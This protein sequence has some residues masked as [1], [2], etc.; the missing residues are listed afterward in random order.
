MRFLVA[1]DKFKD[2]LSAGYVCRLASEHL[3]SGLPNVRVSEIPLTDG[4]EGF[5]DI[6]TGAVGGRFSSHIV[7][8]PLGQPVDVRIGYVELGLLS[9]KVRELANLPSEGEVAV[10]EM[11][12]AAGLEQVP[13]PLRDPWSAS[14]FGVGELVLHAVEDGAAAILLGIGGSATNDLGF[15][16]LRA[17]GLRFFDDED[18]E[19][20]NVCPGAWSGIARISGELPELPPL[21]IACDV[22]NPLLGSTGASA[23]YGPQKGLLAEDILQMDSEMARMAS[24][25]SDQFGAKKDM[26]TAPGT[27]AAG[28]FGFGLSVACGGCFVE[29]FPLVSAW[30]ELEEQINDAE[31]I[32]TGEGRFDSTSLRG[33][34]PGKVL[35]LAHLAGKPVFVLA[36]SVSEESRREVR[37]VF[38][39]AFL[40]SI[41]RPELSLEENLSRTEEFFEQTL[42]KIV[43]DKE[44]TM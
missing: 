20:E 3:E 24:M 2:A 16:A 15:G 12:S 39:R 28:G 32:L 19:I 35:E 22:D 29:G 6:L 44:W 7:E 27:G 36:G 30:L 37:E 4:G 42:Q 10:L 8:G 21:R 17:L 11:A 13:E 33:K 38:P 9:S 25:L 23:S 14:T 26:L 18:Y 40:H 31:I 43:K 1:F 41:G 5:C 34:G